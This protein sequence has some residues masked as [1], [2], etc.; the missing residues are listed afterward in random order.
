LGRLLGRGWAA[1]AVSLTGAAGLPAADWQ[2]LL[3]NSPYGQVS[4]TAPGAPGELEF[5]GV[6][7]EQGGYLVNLYNPAT[8]TAQWIPVNG[9]APGLEV[10][11]YDATTDKLQILQGGRQATLSLKQARVSQLTASAGAPSAAPKS[12]IAVTP[13][14]ET[15]EAR[16]A[17]MQALIRS[18][19]QGNGLGRGPIRA[20][21]IPPEAQAIIDEARRRRAENQPAARPPGQH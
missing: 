3:A 14:N 18:R 4:T 6:V 13:G 21:D 15:P 5:R 9:R 20:D 10:K 2:T 7:N 12:G 19:Q 8:N 11:S 17:R 1:F 16:L